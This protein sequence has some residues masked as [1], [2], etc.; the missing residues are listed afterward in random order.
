MKTGITTGFCKG[1][2]SSDLVE[3]LKHL[4]ACILETSH[5][6]L[7]PVIIFSH[8]ISFKADIKQRDARDWLRRIEH[9]VSIRSQVWDKKDYVKNGVMDLDSIN[10]DL[11]ECHAQVLWKRPVSYL[12]IIESFKEAME[13]FQGGLSTDQMGTKVQKIHSSI[14]SRLELYKR[15]L[16]GI[17]TYASTTLQRLEIQRSLV[18]FPPHKTYCIIIDGTE[19]KV[20]NLIAQRESKLSFQMA[21]DQRKIALA[22]KRDSSAMKTIAI[23][24]I[25]FL[26]GTFI[27]VGTLFTFYSQ[28]T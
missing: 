16:Q 12:Q 28:V 11:V 23:L 24:G 21:G 17:D 19:T 6:M 2:P 14:A 3:C 4:K 26:P 22:S 8:D 1:T 15:R 7:L 27:A 5:P 9:A 18:S 10:R 20:M 25:V 13:I